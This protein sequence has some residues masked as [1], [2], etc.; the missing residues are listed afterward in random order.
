[1]EGKLVIVSAPSGSGKST[2]INHLLKR[3]VNLEFSISATTREPRSGEEDGR[4]YYF[5]SVPQFKKNVEEGRFAEW[6]EV[7]T[8]HC[9]G[10]LK[11]EIERI[12]SNGNHV[13]FDVDVKGGLNLKKIFGN[14]ALSVFIMPPSLEELEKR[15]LLR[16]TDNIEKVRMRLRKASDEIQLSGKFDHVIVNDNLED[17]LR[18]FHKLVVG[19]LT[20][21]R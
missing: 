6:E 11:S 16:K 8:D 19:F 3:G 17:A 18:E 13:L 21:S 20:V 7:Y 10:T 4:E 5:M 14:N 12:W 2:M 1:M 15:L 9:Y